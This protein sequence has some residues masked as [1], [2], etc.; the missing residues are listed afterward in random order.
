MST[1]VRKKSPLWS[2]PFEY[3][4]P[5]HV[6]GVITTSWKIG[7]HKHGLSI[8]SSVSSAPGLCS[9]REGENEGEDEVGDHFRE[10]SSGHAFYVQDNGDEGLEENA[11]VTLQGVVDEDVL[12]REDTAHWKKRFSLLAVALQT[13]PVI[14]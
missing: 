4:H 2:D 5:K 7:M 1:L 14:A 8:P 11:D 13:T 9:V 12:P 3:V 10:G 6:H